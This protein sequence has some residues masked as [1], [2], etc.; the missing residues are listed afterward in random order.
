M[1]STDLSYH[2]HSGLQEYIEAVIFHHYLANNTLAS[3]D[4]I[5]A[6]LIFTLQK[7]ES[8]KPAAT[9]D[10]HTGKVKIKEQTEISLVKNETPA[11]ISH[12]VTEHGIVHS[13]NAAVSEEPALSALD[14]LSNNPAPVVTVWTALVRVPPT[15]YMLGLADFTGELMR[16][17]INSVG[18][19]DLDT[20]T[21]VRIIVHFYHIHVYSFDHV[22][23]FCVVHNTLNVMII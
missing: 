6:E 16:M 22:L 11:P 21:V 14:G 1:L 20:P 19:G 13:E 15:E 9:A 10:P 8:H 5:Q 2:S 4:S 23:F 18:S 12:P 17:S 3:L 7:T